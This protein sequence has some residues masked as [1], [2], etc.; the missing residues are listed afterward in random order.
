MAA[1]GITAKPSLP[2]DGVNALPVLTGDAEAVPVKRFWQ[3]NRYDPVLT[4]NAAMRDGPWKL[5]WPRI[6]EAMA[7][8][9]IDNVWYRGMFAVPH[10]ETA[11][12]RS[13]IARTLSAPGKPELY[14][15]EAD[16]YERENLAA[17]LPE[18]LWGM[19]EELEDWF[20]AVN[21]ERRSLPDAWDGGR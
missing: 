4:C 17:V 6:P 8:F 10:F 14:N 5:Y 11:V 16:P 3:F 20:D 1:S 21:A 18:R 2:L 19:Q 12:D 13:P 15:L 9:T 7:K